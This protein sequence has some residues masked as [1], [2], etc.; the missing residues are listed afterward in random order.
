[1]SAFNNTAEDAPGLPGSETFFG[2]RTSTRSHG[3]SGRPEF[4]HEP[5]GT[6]VKIE[7]QLGKPGL[8][9]AQAKSG[10]LLVWLPGLLQVFGL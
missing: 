1:M 2:Y 9:Q 10:A 5:Q 7:K 8:K 6:S 3:N 4:F